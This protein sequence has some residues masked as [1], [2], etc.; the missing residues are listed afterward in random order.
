MCFV[1]ATHLLVNRFVAS[2]RFV[3]VCK[4]LYHLTNYWNNTHLIPEIGIQRI[5]TT[6]VFIRLKDS[7]HKICW[8]FS[9]RNITAVLICLWYC[10]I[11]KNKTIFNSVFILFVRYL[12]KRWCKTFEVNPSKESDLNS[13]KVY[14][15][16]YKYQMYYILNIFW[17]K[18]YIAKMMLLKTPND[19]TM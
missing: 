13:C 14:D 3:S 12:K 8:K 17:I 18:F 11:L 9:C 4:S 1:L 6:V 16:S 15:S 7:V 19:N 5:P 2:L 10:F